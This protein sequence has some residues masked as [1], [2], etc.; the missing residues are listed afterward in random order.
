MFAFCFSQALPVP[1][2]N[3]IGEMENKSA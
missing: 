1:L 2:Q 3:E